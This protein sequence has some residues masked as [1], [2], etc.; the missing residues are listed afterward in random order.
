MWKWNIC[1]F[2]SLPAPPRPA[3]PTSLNR[4]TSSDVSPHRRQC[5]K[6]HFHLENVCKLCQFF[7]RVICKHNF[8]FYWRPVL[9]P[10]Q[11]LKRRF[12]N[13]PSFQALP[14]SIS[15]HW[16]MY[17]TQSRSIINLEANFLNCFFWHTTSHWQIRNMWFRAED[18][19]M[20]LSASAKTR[21]F[22]FPFFRGNVYCV[23]NL[24]IWS[25]FK[26]FAPLPRIWPKVDI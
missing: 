7:C 10:H 3:P 11:S 9:A 22:I 8:L 20:G 2:T 14:T 13:E 1:I 6:T 24:W 17:E 23:F 12:T 25:R 21:F 16:S 26:A 5:A 4:V 15:T 18:H 19:G